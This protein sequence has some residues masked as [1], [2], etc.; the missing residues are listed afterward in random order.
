MSKSR[1]LA[2]VNE[3]NSYELDIF[4]LNQCL[5]HIGIKSICDG[6]YIAFAILDEQLDELKDILPGF[7]DLGIMDLAQALNIVEL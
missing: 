1:F 5:E 3:D 4:Q 7:E 6:K 2:M